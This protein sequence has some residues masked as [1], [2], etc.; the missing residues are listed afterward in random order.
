MNLREFSRGLNSE[1]TTYSL[2]YGDS[3]TKDLM[4]VLPK[5]KEVSQFATQVDKEILI[6]QYIAK[7]VA[8]FNEDSYLAGHVNGMELTLFVVETHSDIRNG[9]SK[10]YMYGNKDIIDMTIGKVY[11]LPVPIIGDGIINKVIVRKVRRLIR[12]IKFNRFIR[13]KF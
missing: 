3:V 1:T 13:L 5:T 7:H 10:S 12:R 9:I 11:T 2:G 8:L 6:K 4:V